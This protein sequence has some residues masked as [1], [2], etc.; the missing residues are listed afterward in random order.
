MRRA[1]K[2]VA[3]QATNS[4]VRVPPGVP[5]FRALVA[6]PGE[7]APFTRERPR[8]QILPGAPS[9]GDGSTRQICHRVLSG[10]SS[11]VEC[12]LAKVKAEGSTPSARSN[13][14]AMPAQGCCRGEFTRTRSES[15]HRA[16]LR[17]G[18]GTAR[19]GRCTCNADS[20][21]VQSPHGPP[22]LS[23]RSSVAECLLPKQKAEGSTPSARSKRRAT[24]GIAH[25]NRHGHVAGCEM[26]KA[27]VT[28]LSERAQ[29]G[30]PQGEAGGR[31]QGQGRSLQG[32]GKLK[33]LRGWA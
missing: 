32:S 5:S 33:I 30:C 21:W 22:G 7:S 10:R 2:P 3:L 1:A 19:G 13:L 17:R 31:G 6:Q 25:A 29:E 28:A 18:H 23:G 12:D 9:S 24:M 27:R 20:R 11:A 14:R 26:C 4:G 8:V 16:W 15:W